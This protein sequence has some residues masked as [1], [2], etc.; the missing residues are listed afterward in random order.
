ME[1]IME[2]VNILFIP[3]VYLHLETKQY[4]EKETYL[5]LLQKK[6]ADIGILVIMPQEIIHCLIL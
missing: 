3:Q 2:V 1:L 6:Q 5:I 4:I